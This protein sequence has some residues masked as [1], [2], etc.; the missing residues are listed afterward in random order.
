[1]RGLEKLHEK[2]YRANT[3]TDGHRDSMKESA[4]GRFFENGFCL[5]V[6]LHQQGS[7]PEVSTRLVYKE[8][9]AVRHI[10]CLTYYSPF[11]I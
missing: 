10:H 11:I 9:R 7:A 2:G 3:H 6:E 5:F 8:T 4:K 1:M